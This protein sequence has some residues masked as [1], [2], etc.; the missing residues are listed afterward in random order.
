MSAEKIFK[1]N[2]DFESAQKSLAEYHESNHDQNEEKLG[3]L[4]WCFRIACAL[5]VAETIAWILDLSG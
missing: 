1:T 3:L 2:T 4:F 5:L